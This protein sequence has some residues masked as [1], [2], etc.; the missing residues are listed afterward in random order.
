MAQ[1]GR[2]RNRR[3]WNGRLWLQ[4]RCSHGVRL[5]LALGCK[6]SSKGNDDL[7]ELAAVLQI[8]AHFHH[9]VELEYT[10]DDRLQRAARKALGDVLDCALSARLGASHPPDAVPL[11]HS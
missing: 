2:S 5:M 6:I 11:D 4:N 8:A 10:I 1:S 9:I 7:T 3:S